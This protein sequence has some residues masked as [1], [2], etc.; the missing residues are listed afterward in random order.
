M[1]RTATPA[2]ARLP[3]PTDLTDAQW[4]QVGP[5]IPPESPGGRHR[6]V[7]MRE[8]VNGIN[9]LTRTGCQWR[10]IPRDLPNWNTCRHYYDRFRRDGTWQRLHDALRGRVRVAA[11]REPS[12]SAACVDSQSVRSAEKR[13]PAAGTTR[14][15]G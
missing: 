4:E 8:V 10:A 6:E 12:P 2:A 13:G 15:S 7:D 1:E 11:G 14:A 5:M 3:Y 9:Y